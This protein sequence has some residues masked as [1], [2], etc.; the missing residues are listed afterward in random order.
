MPPRPRVQAP[1]WTAATRRTC[2]ASSGRPSERDNWGLTGDTG[3]GEL[4]IPCFFDRGTFWVL[5]LNYFYIPKHASAYLFPQS[6][7]IHDFC[8]GPISV[9]PIC[10]QPKAIATALGQNVAKPG[11]GFQAVLI[12]CICLYHLNNLIMFIIYAFI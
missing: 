3:K 7:K 2:W 5:P 10:P 6:V 8:S 11:A 9:D 12:V 4:Q 1:R